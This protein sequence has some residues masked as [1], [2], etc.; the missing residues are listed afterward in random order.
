MPDIEHWSADDP[1]VWKEKLGDQT[2][3]VRHPS[4]P[5]EATWDG[6]ADTF[7]P[8]IARYLSKVADVLGLPGLLKAGKFAVP[9]AWLPLR[10]DDPEGNADPRA[11]F[12]VT[13]YD[14]AGQDPIDR[15]V[16]FVAAE[17]RTPN[18]AATVLGSRLG[19]R[20]VAHIANDADVAGTDHQN[21]RIT[22]A[23]RSAELAKVFELRAHEAVQAFLAFFFT[24]DGF[25]ELS[26]NI[27]RAA[28]LSL[29]APFGIDGVRFR[30]ISGDRAVYDIY[31][32]VPR[33]RPEEDSDSLAYALTAEVVIDKAKPS[34]RV[35]A[36]EKDPL[37]AHVVQANLF[38]QDP[39]SLAG[40]GGLVG[41][42]PNRS[43]QRLANF[44][45]PVTL[46]G[47]VLDAQ[48]EAHLQDN[49]NRLKVTKS[50]LVDPAAVES[51]E[52]VVA[53]AAVTHARMNALAALGGYQRGRA[54][55]DQHHARPLFE[56]LLAYGLSPV[57]YFKFATRPL[58][59]RYRAR[60]RPGPGKDGKTV[61]AQV[62]F[63]PPSLDL[64]GPDAVWDPTK[65]KPL[66][67][68]FALADLQRSVSRREPLGLAADP[69]WSWH[70]Y[71]HA[72]LAA[73]TGALELQFAH[74]AGDALA[75]ITADPWSA[76][77]ENQHLR[78]YT[79]PWVYLHRRHDRSVYDGFGWCGRYHRP[80]R[81]DPVASNRRRK[82]YDSEQILS[83]SLFRLY[84]ALGGDTVLANGTPDRA[85]R[86]R[87]ADYVVYL[88]LK[89]MRPS[90]PGR[91]ER[92]R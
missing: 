82:G 47:I 85:A 63:D 4:Y 65:R 70:E 22:S 23:T 69:R 44:R 19:I 58:I 81:F 61:N 37:V 45:Q 30:N 9:L 14:E 79:F 33:A 83:S 34:P 41:A 25:S 84:R 36:I 64:V 38:T 52:E 16:V 21:V 15:T 18:D 51:Q 66:E 2:I 55:F 46:E 71:F 50:K 24:P 29:G 60:I 17:S 32:S 49:N 53:P 91:L 12:V 54:Q 86:Q 62:D 6:N 7:E 31:A 20:V 68:R 89:M 40:P 1:A 90:A 59:I 73:R 75:A 11:S 80:A 42:R 74:S 48:L 92:H 56:T 26:R 28:G 88:V 43:P 39:A 87:A 67:V 10:L 78:G 3:A 57:Q 5:A 13:R 76:L 77:V 35:V 8:I 72:L 27:R